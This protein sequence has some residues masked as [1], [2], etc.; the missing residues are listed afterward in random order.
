MENNRIFNMAFSKIYPLLLNKAER[1]GRTKAEVDKIITNLTGYS[2]E[3]IEAL[4]KTE[5]TY[6]QFFEKAPKLN[7]KRLNV[8]G[9]ICGVKIAEIENSMMKDMRILDKMIDDLAKGKVLEKILL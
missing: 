7:E 4:L 1:K 2:E 6:S 8:K 5:T 9:S 3:S